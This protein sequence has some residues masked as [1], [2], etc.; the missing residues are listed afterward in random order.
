M[1]SF[2]DIIDVWSSQVALADD[3]SVGVSRV[4]AWRFNNSIPG[5]FWL[6]VFEAAQSRA[7]AAETDDE[8]NRYTAVTLDLLAAIGAGRAGGDAGDE[9]AA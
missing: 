5:S 6:P 1:K 9:D 7:K 2:Q 8:R 4:R 3:L